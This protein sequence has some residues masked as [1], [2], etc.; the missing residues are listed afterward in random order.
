MSQVPGRYLTFGTRDVVISKTLP[1]NNMAGRHC[2]DAAAAAKECR[3][4][5]RTA[6]QLPAGSRDSKGN[7]DSALPDYKPSTLKTAFLGSVMT[8]IVAL[9]V[10][11]GVACSILPADRL[12]S[13]IPTEGLLAPHSNL[14]RSLGTNETSAVDV[15]AA[16]QK[17]PPQCPVD[18][19]IV[20]WLTLVFE[21]DWEYDRALSS[22]VFFCPGNFVNLPG[23]GPPTTTQP[24]TTTSRYWRDGY[25]ITDTIVMF[26]RGGPYDTYC[27]DKWEAE[28]SRVLPSTCVPATSTVLLSMWYYCDGMFENGENAYARVG[29][30][31]VRTTLTPVPN[32]GAGLTQSESLTITL[33]KEPTAAATSRKDDASPGSSVR[34]ITPLPTGALSI[35]TRLTPESQ[36]T[37]AGS[38]PNVRLPGATSRG[39]DATAARATVAREDGDGATVATHVVT[40]RNPAGE[41]T[42][43]R[44]AVLTPTQKTLTDSL[45]SIT[46]VYE[47]PT[48]VATLV[49]TV[50][51]STDIN[52]LTRTATIYINPPTTTPSP[53]VVD[54]IVSLSIA[55]YYAGLLLPT[56]LT[57]L[58]SIP[59]D[60]IHLTAARYQAFHIL[61]RPSGVKTSDALLRK[62]GPGLFGNLKSG[63]ASILCLRLPS[64]TFVTAL[65]A[66]CST[67][68]V[69]IAGQA[70]GFRTRG[71]C[72]KDDFS[73]CAL[74]LAVFLVPAGIVLGL[75][76]LMSVLLFA[77]MWLLPRWR[78]GVTC[79]PWS[80]ASIAA[81]AAGS[82]PS[83]RRLLAADEGAVSQ[84]RVA[85]CLDGSTARLGYITGPETGKIYGI[86]IAE[87]QTRPGGPGDRVATDSGLLIEKT[88]LKKG[89]DV[90]VTFHSSLGRIAFVLFAT[91][92][93][94][95]V[96][97][98]KCTRGDTGFERFM[99]YQSLTVRFLFTSSG[100][101]I[102]LFWASLFQSRRSFTNAV[103]GLRPDSPMLCWLLTLVQIQLSPLHTAAWP[104]PR[105]QQGP[106]LS[107]LHQPI[108]FPVY[109]LPNDVATPGSPLLR[110]QRSWQHFCRYFSATS[111]FMIALP[112]PR[113]RLAAGVLALSSYGW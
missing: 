9:V 53:T 12:P 51:Y 58:L 81:L 106:R 3:D 92:L 29:V 89:K 98:Y 76:A 18:T 63:A 97:Y 36:R 66:L 8:G 56:I 61:T 40:L 46:V 71:S 111:R 28:R 49:P 108:H 2:A 5:P 74:Q 25:T 32:I 60:I 112:I 16:T 50:T 38:G 102:S 104:S 62:L 67:I 44:T 78:T 105:N 1:D 109:I 4:G 52:G 6:E 96:V 33:P 7:D 65:L 41:A 85:Q 19:V 30:S 88:A 95:L 15:G 20:F 80:T 42:A 27:T 55:E 68:L 14:A 91:G 110:L 37:G 72:T 87:G 21:N 23:C 100:V 26:E 90:A 47:L 35:S 99:D 69:P 103:L 22:W 24:R 101:A 70:V 94:I 13:S 77:A 11:L 84:I 48:G 79:D 59:I 31:T 17:A 93:L 39:S 113:S 83:I 82:R 75:L 107:S 34:P 86:I 10:L 45:G 64:I 57:V 73:G 54:E 43:T